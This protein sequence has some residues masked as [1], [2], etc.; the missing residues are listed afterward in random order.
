M[1]RRQRGLTLAEAMTTVLLAATVAGLA[2]PAFTGFLKHRRTEALAAEVATDL[3]FV[4]VESVSRQHAIRVSFEADAAGA[5]CYVI[6]TGGP[7]DC[8]CLTG[9]PATCAAGALEIKTQ[10]FPADHPGVRANVASMLFDPTFGTVS[11]AATI[12]IGTAER[13]GLHNVVSLL[14]R[15]RTCAPPGG[16]P[17]YRAC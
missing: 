17:G 3:Q 16:L 4:R 12:R 1:R 7:G 15:V 8:T 2:I 6:H 13:S 11:P 14:G 9:S 5:T 10:Y